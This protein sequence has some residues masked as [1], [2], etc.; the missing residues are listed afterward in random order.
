MRAKRSQASTWQFSSF[1]MRSAVRL[2]STVP[3][4][5]TPGD[6]ACTCSGDPT[7]PAGQANGASHSGVASLAPE[8][9]APL[10]C[11]A[12]LVGS[13]EQVQALSPG[14]QQ[15]GTVL[16]SLTALR[17]LKDENCQADAWLRFARMP[18]LMLSTGELA[19]YR[20]AATP[21]G[22]FTTLHAAQA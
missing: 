6:K 12:G 7:R 5:C 15:F 17:M 21:R 18:A 10:A 22:N 4:C 16:A 8:W 9:L 2:A 14:V 11:P 19:D 3:N 13:P 20:F 1:S